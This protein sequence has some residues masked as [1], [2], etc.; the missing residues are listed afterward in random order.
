MARPSTCQA[1]LRRSSSG[2]ASRWAGCSTKAS[3]RLAMKRAV[4]TGVPPRV[5][6][7][8]STMPRPVRTSTRRPARV[9]ATSYVRVSPLASITISTRSP[10]TSYTTLLPLGLLHPWRRTAVSP[11]RRFVSRNNPPDRVSERRFRASVVLWRP[12]TAGSERTATTAQPFIGTACGSA[13]LAV[14]I[15]VTGRWRHQDAQRIR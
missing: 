4:R 15:V 9:A 13:V 3:T 1:A 12:V 10:F 11:A 6:S 2:R 7:V 14:P 5:S 8:T